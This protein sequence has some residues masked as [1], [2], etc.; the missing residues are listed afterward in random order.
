MKLSTSVHP[1]TILRTTHVPKKPV[2]AITPNS[3]SYDIWS[4]VLDPL[5]WDGA[6]AE[7][8]ARREAQTANFMVVELIKQI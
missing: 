3:L 5:D 1:T 7:A 2:G 4:E 8:E 6:K